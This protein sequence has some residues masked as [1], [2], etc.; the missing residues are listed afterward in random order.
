MN[1]IT[2]AGIAALSLLSAC[3]G[4]ADA[5]SASTAGAAANYTFV[6][7]KTGAH[8]VYTDKLVDNLT[9]VGS[10]G[11][12]TVH[13]EDPSHDTYV[14]GA[15]DLTVYPT[16]FHY[17]A[18]SQPASWVISRPA[19]T[20]RCASSEGGAGAPSPLALG[21]GWS[22][23][24]TETCGAGAGTAYTQS[25]TLAGIETITVAAGTF[26]AYKFIAST[27]RTI[28]G[29][30]RTETSTRWRDASGGD[31]RTLKSESVF[32]YSGGTPPAGTPVSASRELQSYR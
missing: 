3:G 5:G 12:F 31:T 7:P 2:F 11:S 13:E 27:T 23:H 4:G 10:D 22:T 17:N 8:L 18:I 24:W 6:P 32:A 9:A 28:N 15:T 30:T 16:D 26:K 19:Q 1:R 14:S 25:G 21:A 29:I 20:I